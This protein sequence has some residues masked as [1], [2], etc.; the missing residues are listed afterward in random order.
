MKQHYAF[1]VETESISNRL[2]IPHIQNTLSPLPITTFIFLVMI[3]TAD[4]QNL[5]TMNKVEG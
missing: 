4:Y 1:Q 3:A 2:L 5:I